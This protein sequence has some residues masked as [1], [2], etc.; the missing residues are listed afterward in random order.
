MPVGNLAKIFGPT[1]VGY[2]CPEPEPSDMLKETKKQA[3]VMEKLINVPMDYWNRFINP[4]DENTDINVCD[5]PKVLNRQSSAGSAIRR[6]RGILTHTP[7]PPR[8]TRSQVG[9]P[10]F[11]RRDDLRINTTHRSRPE[12]FFSPI[13]K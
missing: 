3:Q 8:M 4:A 9:F 6:S 10:T 12:R 5:T 1:V 7:L 2:S 11:S 13:I